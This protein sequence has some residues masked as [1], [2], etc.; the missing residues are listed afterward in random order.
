M[1]LTCKIDDRD[2]RQEIMELNAHYYDELRN[3]LPKRC[4]ECDYVVPS[5]R[6]FELPDI[7]EVCQVCFFMHH[8]LYS[9]RLKNVN[10]FRNLHKQWKDPGEQKK[11]RDK[12]GI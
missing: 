5:T 4:K 7:G 11:R 8:A 3:L 2:L 9:D 6:A 12:L 1:S 10:Y